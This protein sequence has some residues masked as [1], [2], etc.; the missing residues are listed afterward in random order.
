M[1]DI[2]NDLI[3]K[4]RKVEGAACRIGTLVREV[5]DSSRIRVV[6][7]TGIVNVVRTLCDGRAR[8]QRY[9][10]HQSDKHVG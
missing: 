10:R 3:F 4:K 6:L 5:A 8:E 2:E 1:H 7:N 9:D